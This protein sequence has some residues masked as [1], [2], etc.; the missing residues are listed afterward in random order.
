MAGWCNKRMIFFTT[1]F[2][3][4]QPRKNFKCKIYLDNGSYNDFH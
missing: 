4:F 1:P 2:E 3:E